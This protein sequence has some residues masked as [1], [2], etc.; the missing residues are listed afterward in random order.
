M[1]EERNCGTCAFWRAGAT[2]PTDFPA[3]AESFED[4]G[5]CENIVPQIYII[6]N[7]PETLQPIMHRTRCCAEW[8]DAW[9]D[10]DGSDPDGGEPVPKPDGSRVH[11]LFPIQEV[12]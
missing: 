2:T 1:S 6:G 4:V 12:A 11:Q 10:D 5:A 3:R 8:R 9:P 7:R